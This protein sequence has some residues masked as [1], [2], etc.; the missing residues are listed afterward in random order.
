MM[1]TLALNRLIAHPICIVCAISTRQ[2]NWEEHPEAAT[3]GVL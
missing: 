2:K 3:W 1:A